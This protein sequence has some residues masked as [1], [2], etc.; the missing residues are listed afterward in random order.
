MSLFF[1]H[2]SQ[3]LEDRS[4]LSSSKFGFVF[5]ENMVERVLS[6]EKHSMSC[7]GAV[8]YKR[9]ITSLYLESLHL[10]KTALLRN[11]TMIEPAAAHISKPG[12]KI[13]LDK[14]EVITGEEEEHNVLQATSKDA[15]Y[16][17]AA[18]HHRLVALRSSAEQ[19]SDANHID[20]ESETAFQL[21]NCDSDEDDEK[22]TQVSS[23]GTD[24]SNH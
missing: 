22:I 18:I 14:V 1:S 23:S 16:L 21:L 8:S 2:R 19:E 7:N 3:L 20:S 24:E 12:E 4:V 17:Y 6:P 9:E 11:A 10:T 5:G 15:G 13:L